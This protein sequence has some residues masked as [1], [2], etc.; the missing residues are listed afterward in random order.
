MTKYIA[1]PQYPNSV[2]Y[3]WPLI[4]SPPIP[5]VRGANGTITLPS[6]YPNDV[7]IYPD[8]QS[9]SI[10]MFVS[11]VTESAGGG[12]SGSP[13]SGAV[14][15]YSFGSL[16]DIFNGTFQSRS[17]IANTYGA[18]GMAIQPGTG[19]LYIAASTLVSGGVQTSANGG[20][21]GFTYASYSSSSSPEMFVFTDHTK[22]TSTFAF[23]S[24]VAFDLHG[25]LWLTTFELHRRCSAG[26]LPQRRP[27]G[28][29]IRAPIRLISRSSTE[30][31]RC[32][33]LPFSLRKRRLAPHSHSPLRKGLPSI[34]WGT[35]GWATAISLR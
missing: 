3:I 13:T 29:Q 31:L 4:G 30:L 2:I 6:G 23:C 7:L 8:P 9:P 12:G 15:F 34:R 5:V 20:I 28:D 35:F 14:W 19:D 24:N 17:L 32:R 26:V 22:D 16:D 10:Y 21:V 27:A 1:N 33:R 25:N 18:A 11:V